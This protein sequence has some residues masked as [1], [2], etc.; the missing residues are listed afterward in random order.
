MA[1]AELEETEL[2]TVVER[3][4]MVAGVEQAAEQ[5]AGETHT[6]S[7]AVRIP[8]GSTLPPRESSR[9]PGEGASVRMAPSDVTHQEATCVVPRFVTPA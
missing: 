1:A 7:C 9:G 4:A 2:S 3:S 8:M 5:E 6:L